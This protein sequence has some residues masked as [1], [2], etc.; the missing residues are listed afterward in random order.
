MLNITTTVSPWLR[1]AILYAAS[2][3]NVVI[4]ALILGWFTDH[5]RDAFILTALWLAS[6][7]VFAAIG[8]FVA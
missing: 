4:V 8:A 6:I 3:T 2:T 1:D 7:V 5:T